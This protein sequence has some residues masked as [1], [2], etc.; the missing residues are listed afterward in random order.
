MRN[1]AASTLAFVGGFVL[2][3]LEVIGARYLA[4][5]FG[6]SFYVWV[7]QIGVVLI[8]LAFGYY[9]GGTLADRCQR[10]SLLSAVL[11]PSGLLT[12]LI[13]NFSNRL[14]TAL[15]LRHPTDH[16]IP[17]LWQKLDPVLGSSLVF[18]LPCFGLATLSPYLIR[19]RAQSLAHVGRTSGLIIAASTVGSIAGVFVSGYVLIDHLNAPD[20]FRLTGALTVL[21]GLSCFFMDGWFAKETG[22]AAGAK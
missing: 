7:S 18:L 13:P 6:G 11:V 15:I 2:M 5:D 19:L 1:F 16:D 9:V 8:A 12:C 22:E 3:A 17:I 10:L 4:K 20:I 21:L 14:I